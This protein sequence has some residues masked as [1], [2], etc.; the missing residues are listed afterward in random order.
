[1]ENK[2]FMARRACGRLVFVT[3]AV[4]CLAACAP[5]I[6]KGLRARA[7]AAPP[8]AELLRG[9][10]A[11]VGQSVV[12]GGY[13]I[14]IENLREDSRLVVLQAPTSRGYR[15]RDRDLSEGRFVAHS[16]S[17]LDPEIFSEGRAI[18]VGGR[19]TGVS[20]APL[21]RAVYRYPMV[22]IE[23]IHIWPEASEPLSRPPTYPYGWDPWWP[24][25]NLDG[26]S[27]PVSWS[28]MDP[29]VAHYTAHMYWGWIPEKCYVGFDPV[30]GCEPDLT[31]GNGIVISHAA[32]DC[33]N[34][35]GLNDSDANL[36]FD[37][38][39][40]EDLMNRN[41]DGQ[42]VPLFLAYDLSIIESDLVKNPSGTNA[43]LFV[44]G[45][46]EEPAGGDPD[47]PY[48]DCRAL[49]NL[50]PKLL[51]K[52]ANDRESAL[53]PVFTDVHYYCS[54]SSVLPT[55]NFREDQNEGKYFS[56]ASADDL[57]Q[58]FLSVAGRIKRGRLIE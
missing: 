24:W 18:T 30:P 57:G 28:P 36:H 38:V 33:L 52:I 5:V 29:N 49:W 54:H 10:E 42:T 43:T 56:S 4:C 20:E 7:S 44:V 19:V 40:G 32:R 53:D 39:G 35:F 55:S 9:P 13:I 27:E 23:E 11:F 34:S 58:M 50:H 45:F 17:F 41:D 46:G 15:P 14:E 37:S 26:N 48:E 25:G 1:M 6:S 3:I 2:I 16:R 31:D 21:G 51:K 12:L 22:E 8:F 47:D